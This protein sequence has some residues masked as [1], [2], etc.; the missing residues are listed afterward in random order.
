M[1]GWKFNNGKWYFYKNGQPVKG[2]YKFTLA[3]GEKTE[4]WSFFDRSTGVLYTGWHWMTK[5]EGETTE[6]WSYFG[7][8]GWLRTGWQ[9]LTRKEDG[10]ATDHWSYFGSNGWL[11][12]GWVYFDQ[13]M[14]E[15]EPHWSFFGQNGWM[16][17]GL[18]WLGNAD[19]EK[20]GHYC[21]FNSNG[22][23]KTNCD[24]SVDRKKYKADGRGWLTLI[25]DTSS[26]GTDTGWNYDRFI[27]F[28]LG[29]ATDYDGAYGAQCVDLIKI[30]LFRLWGIKPGAWGDAHAYY[31]NF[32]DH[33]ELVKN[34]ERIPNTFD[35]VPKKGDIVVW[36][37]ALNGCY[38]HIA[39]ATGVGNTSYFESYDQ[40]WTGNHDA[41]TRIR[42][43]YKYL[44]GVLRPKDRS[45]VA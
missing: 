11:R 2:W 36:D 23:L 4:H 15:R 1:T 39:I 9:Y 40:N 13:V 6:H 27:S 34:F 33:P 43:S 17:T 28:Y 18:Q 31:D 22:W 41:C 45:K 3:E 19:G 30:Y 35:F 32:Y 16:R 42:H 12:T 20:T 24:I 8:N 44:K 38:G 14:G 10:E 26:S 29:K 25:S 5:K 37:K 21:Y 7:K